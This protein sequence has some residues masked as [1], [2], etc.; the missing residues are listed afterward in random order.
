MG[1]GLNLSD[2]VKPEARRAIPRYRPTP[3]E[4]VRPGITRSQPADANF[5]DRGGLTPLYMIASRLGDD[6]TF[7]CYSITAQTRITRTAIA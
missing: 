7:S 4:G 6:D 1:A 2:E 5:P 3:S